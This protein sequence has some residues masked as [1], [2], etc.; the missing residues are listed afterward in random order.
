M[1]KITLTALA[2]LGLFFS[3]AKAQAH[4]GYYHDGM[5]EKAMDKCLNKLDLNAD[6]KAKID[7]ARK[8]HREAMDKI[9]DRK[10]GHLKELQ[11]KVDDKASDSELRASLDDIKA[12]KKDFQ[13]QME[14]FHESLEDILTPRQKALMVLDKMKK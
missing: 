8:S 7:D 9:M 4:E 10:K 1:K 2:L 3:T 14:K 12:D 6:Q 11:T 5:D 13:Q